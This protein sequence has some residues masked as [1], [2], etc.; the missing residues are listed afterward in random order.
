MSERIILAGGSG[1]LGRSLAKHLGCLGYETLILTRSKED[2]PGFA[3]WDGKNAGD[4]AR[5]LE[6]AKA[7]V[8]LAGR[9]VDCR[10]T[11]DNRREIVESRVDSAKALG[12]AMRQCR[13]PP[14]TWIQAASLAI[15]GDAGDAILDD[16]GPH[17][18]GFSVDVC[19]KWES[20]VHA[21][22]PPNVRKVILRIGFALATDGGA[23]SRLA[24]LTRMGLGGTVGS[25]RQF[26]SWL[27][28]DDLNRM[29]AWCIENPNARGTYNATGPSPVANRE[30]MASLRR[31]LGWPWSPP[32]PSLAVRIGAY[33]M[34]T[35]ASLALT[36]R[37]CVP[38][39]LLGEGFSFRHVDLSACLRELFR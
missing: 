16:D 1:F 36:G 4:W 23:L 29:M 38:T 32:A 17:G 5:H 37:R 28:V 7:V 34:G 9:S 33:V 18:S 30:F 6:G 21:Q 20:E 22:A 15:Y 39:R 25:G 35:D 19:E 14:T 8:N 27:H 24:R 2:R 31:A 11:A 13:V 10:Y 26:I 3:R 12:E